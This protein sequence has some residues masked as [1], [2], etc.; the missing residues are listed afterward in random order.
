MGEH[1]VRIH[2]KN[3][4]YIKELQKSTPFLS[5]Y[6]DTVNYVISLA[7]RHKLI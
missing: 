1:H 3:E 7:Q 6:N 4:K 2:E 5:S